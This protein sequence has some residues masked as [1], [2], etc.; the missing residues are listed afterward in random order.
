MRGGG[1]GEG[2]GN[3]PEHANIL[4]GIQGGR[5]KKI[6][7]TVNAKNTKIETK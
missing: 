1:G 5:F 4:P 2:R 7:I 6:Y 3:L